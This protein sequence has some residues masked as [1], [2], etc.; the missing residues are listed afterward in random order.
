MKKKIF[1]YDFL[2]V[3]AGLIGCLAAISLHKKNFKVL[4]IEKD[5]N[6]V[7]DKRTLAVNANSRKFLIDLNFW[8]KLHRKS[9]AIEQ[10]I[11]SDYINKKKITFD[12]K[13]QS[14]GSVIF[15]A[16]LQKISNEYL[17]KNSLLIE[18]INFEKLNISSL[19]SIKIKNNFYNFKKVILALGKNF[20]NADYVK[21]NRFEITHKAYVGFFK[22]QKKHF[23]TAYETFTSR[24]P[25]AVLPCPDKSKKFSTFIFSTKD[26]VSKKILSDKLNKFFTNTHGKININNEINEFPIAAHLTRPLKKNFIL[27]GDNSRAIHPV[28]GQGWNL[29][30]KDIQALLKQLDEYSISDEKFDEIYF[31]RRQIENFSYLV[32][33]NTLNSIYESESILAKKIIKAGFS[34][35]NNFSF[36]RKIF[37]SQA[38]GTKNLI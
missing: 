1:N 8:T 24:G 15:N 9:E 27:L 22:H 16:D 35:F 21:K 23:Q 14:M 11:I 33:T 10:I 25:I 18:N 17:K 4:V 32:F 34:I 37:I 7:K 26:Q 36:L 28:A 38:M 31:N 20:N 12:D 3:G 13:N 5:K 30:V 2:I 29:G 6:L 19:N